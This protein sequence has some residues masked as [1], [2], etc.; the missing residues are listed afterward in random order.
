[1]KAAYLI[2][3]KL[4]EEFEHNGNIL[5]D[6]EGTNVWV[7]AVAMAALPDGIQEDGTI[8]LRLVLRTTDRS[9]TNPYVDGTDV[10]VYVDEKSKKVEFAREDLWIDG[11][12]LFHGG[13]V[14]TAL[15]WVRELAEPFYLQLK[16]P[17]LTPEQRIA[18]ND[19]DE[20]YV[21]PKVKEMIPD[22]SI[23]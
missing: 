10:Y 15:A 21:L 9:G 22:H 14:P 19:E 16:D 17:F 7:M 20:D 8:T 3:D 6:Q 23:S 2:L 4:K 11:P 5:L 18:L 1:M 12:P 13:T